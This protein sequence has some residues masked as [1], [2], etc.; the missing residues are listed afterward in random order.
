MSQPR[1]R[2]PISP[3]QNL[4]QPFTRSCRDWANRARSRPRRA[5]IGL[6]ARRPGDRM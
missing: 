6:A 2:H 4:V 5:A 1:A 3:P